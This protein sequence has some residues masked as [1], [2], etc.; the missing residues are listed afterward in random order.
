[1]LLCH[2]TRTMVDGVVFVR[3]TI[4]ENRSVRQRIVVIRS[5]RHCSGTKK[6]ICARVG[7]ELP[8]S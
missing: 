1:M 6:T 4:V 3:Q 5:G 2:L 8:V 7:E